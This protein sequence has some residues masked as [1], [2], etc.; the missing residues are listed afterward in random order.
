MR[1]F[2]HRLECG[3]MENL[4]YALVALAVWGALVSLF[5]FCAT[6]EWPWQIVRRYWKDR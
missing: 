5:M 3:D 1:G 2:T 6:G 4:L